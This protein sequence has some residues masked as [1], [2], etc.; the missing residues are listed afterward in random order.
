MTLIDND[1]FTFGF[2]SVAAMVDIVRQATERDEASSGT[3]TDRQLDAR[4]T[5]DAL[6][7]LTQGGR[8]CV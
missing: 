5:G 7:L 1:A 2:S 4:T 8:P 3:I 6:Y